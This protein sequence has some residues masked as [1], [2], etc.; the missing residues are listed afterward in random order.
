MVLAFTTMSLSVK[1]VSV[2]S[3]V[4]LSKSISNCVSDNCPHAITSACSGLVLCWA[5]D[6]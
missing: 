5:T 6:A 2:E 4:S 3:F 1:S